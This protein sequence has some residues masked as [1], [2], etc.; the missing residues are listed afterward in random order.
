[1]DLA[2]HVS[3]ES[4]PDVMFGFAFSYP[5]K[6][7]GDGGFMKTPA[8][9]HA[10][11]VLGGPHHPDPTQGVEQLSRTKSAQ[12]DS[13]P[14]LAPAE[15]PPIIPLTRVVLVNNADRTVE[16]KEMEDTGRISKCNIRIH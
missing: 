14:R 15:M 6:N 7:I 9:D 3:C 10:S 11:I 16:P 12:L 13:C 2:D 8:G 5:A 4:K 1:M